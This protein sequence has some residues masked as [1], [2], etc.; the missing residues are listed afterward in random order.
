MDRRSAKVWHRLKEA[1]LNAAILKGQGVATEYGELASLRQSGDIDVW[2]L[3][4]YDK[5]CE[6]VQSVAPT[7]DVAYHRFHFEVFKDTEVELH[8]RPTLMRN[9]FD[10]RKL[11]RWYNSFHVDSF[12]F[13][14]D[15]GFAVPS[16]DFNRIFILTHIY[17][18]FLFEGIGLRQVMDF[19]FVLLNSTGNKD[20]LKLLK[21]F[22]LTRFAQAIMWILYSQFGLEREKLMACGMNEKEGRFVLNEIMT[23]GNFGQADQRYRYVHLRKVRQKLAHGA[24]LISHYPLEVVWTPI[25]LLYHRYW[26]KQTKRNQKKI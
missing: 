23:T 16:Y 9:L 8:H 10:D 3:G 6:Y 18:H 11:T 21:D 25:W 22:R 26:K 2:V 7:K 17:R 14:E 4:G 20:E 15:K 19:Y 12:R 13:L 1:G 24:H 5:V